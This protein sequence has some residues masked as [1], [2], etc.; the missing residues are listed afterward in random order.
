MISTAS[1]SLAMPTFPI[2]N[3]RCT[4]HKLR[5]VPYSTLERANHLSLSV[6]SSL[7][8]LPQ[9]LYFRTL[10]LDNIFSLLRLIPAFFFGLG[11]PG[12]LLGTPN[13]FAGVRLGFRPLANSLGANSASPSGTIS[14]RRFFAARSWASC[15]ASSSSVATRWRFF[16]KIPCGRA[17]KV[18]VG[19]FEDR[20][21]N[22]AS[23]SLSTGL[24]TDVWGL[25][26][27]P[28]PITEVGKLP[29]ISKGG[30]IDGRT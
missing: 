8:V 10:G 27:E 6:S 2:N 29:G 28:W 17:L 12:A 3:H 25:L 4:K 18:E 11:V 15:S 9:G 30:A 24:K 19:W 13:R 23:F 1:T 21:V 14:L 20:A 7:P 26:S 5:P 16:V 22:G